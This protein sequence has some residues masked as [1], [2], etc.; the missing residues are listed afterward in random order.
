MTVQ[1]VKPRGTAA[2]EQQPSAS[3]ILS[4]SGEPHENDKEQSTRNCYRGTGPQDS[5]NLLGCVLAETGSAIFAGPLDMD[6]HGPSTFGGII[7]AI[8]VIPPCLVEN[9]ATISPHYIAYIET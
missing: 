1:K 6:I 9:E 5:E 4:P 2:E 8:E 3:D 7:C